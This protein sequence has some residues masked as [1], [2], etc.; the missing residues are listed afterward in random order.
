MMAVPGPNTI[1]AQRLWLRE[2]RA[3]EAA[4][5]VTGAHLAGQ[6][7]ADGYPIEG[8]L[9]AARMLAALAASGSYRAGF[10]MYQIVLVDAGLV[11]GDI[12]FHTAPDEAGSVEIGYGIVPGSRGLGIATEAA[13]ALTSWALAQPGVIEVRAETDASNTASQRVLHRSGFVLIHADAAM[14][15]YV[16][17]PE[18]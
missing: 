18:L 16:L 7:W 12:G 6:A 5:L 11:V 1:V 13:R 3:A 4:Q 8:T 15:H 2:L 9:D 17:T 14:H 10:G